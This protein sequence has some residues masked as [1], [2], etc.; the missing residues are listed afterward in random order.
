MI[1][2][3]HITTISTTYKEFFSIFF[4]VKDYNFVLS[5]V[6]LYLYRVL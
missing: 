1:I 6:S 3:R 5:A 4:S 2:L